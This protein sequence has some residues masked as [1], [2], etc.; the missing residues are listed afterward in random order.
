MKYDLIIVG[1]G[2]AGI[3]A[4]IYAAR[5]KLRTALLSADFIGQVGLSGQ[6]ENWPGE[7]SVKGAELIDKFAQ[8]LR[9]QNIDMLEQSVESIRQIEGGF[10]V[11]AEDMQYRTS[12]VLLATGRIPKQLNVP[13]EKKY[14]GKGVVYCTTCDAPVYQDKQVLVVGGGNYGFSSAI[15]LTDYA[16]TVT[17]VERADSVT[18]DEILRDR[19]YQAGVNVR[20]GLSV[21][22]I[23]GDDYVHT[24]KLSDGSTLAV[25]GVFVDIGSTAQTDIVPDDVE[26]NGAK[27]IVIDPRTNQTSVQGCYA[28]GDATDIRDKQIVVAAAEGAKAAL[29]IYDHLRA[30]GH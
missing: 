6:V 2:P 25:D 8:H 5:K 18:A 21:A 4:G 30:P 28:A 11:G 10:L 22:E 27:E 3:A 29:S 15:E 26:L 12:T 16:A 17:L 14:T 19:A 23:V 1:G 9:A 7:I 20:S 13:G 24:V